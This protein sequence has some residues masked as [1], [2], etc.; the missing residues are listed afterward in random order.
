[1]EKLELLK[2]L[3]NI[4]KKYEYIDDDETGDTLLKIKGYYETDK[5]IYI[6]FYELVLLLEHYSGIDKIL[7]T[8]E[9]K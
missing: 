7:L 9:E 4:R 3:L 6:N 2:H 1:M 5:V 8:D